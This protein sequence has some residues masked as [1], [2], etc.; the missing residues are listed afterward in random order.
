M[1]LVLGFCFAIFFVQF[2]ILTPDP[3]AVVLRQFL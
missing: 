1:A 2:L 3:Y